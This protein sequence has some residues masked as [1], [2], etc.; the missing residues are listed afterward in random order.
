[1][2]KTNSLQIAFNDLS[3]SNEILDYSFRTF[4]LDLNGFISQNY[5]K[6]YSFETIRKTVSK[7]N[8]GSKLETVCLSFLDDLFKKLILLNYINHYK[9]KELNSKSKAGRLNEYH[10][11]DYRK[12]MFDLKP[13]NR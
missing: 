2:L 11:A 6:I 4:L 5:N 9:E 3:I 10:L 8:S 13:I 1:M 7:T 12:S